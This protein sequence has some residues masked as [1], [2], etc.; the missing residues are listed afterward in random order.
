ITA[1][2]AFL[3][4]DSTMYDLGTLGGT[5]SFACGIN[6]SG[7][8]VGEASITGD[9]A[10]HAFLY[11]G[12][13][14]FDLNT[15]IDPLSGWI[16]ESVMDIN[17]AGLIV[18]KGYNGSQYHAFL[19]TPVPEPSTVCLLCLDLIGFLTYKRHSQKRASKTTQKHIQSVTDQFSQSLITISGV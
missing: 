8:I 18:G 3:Y 10:S 15:L 11:S 19:L 17:D 14:M 9:A 16:L 13:T 12:S 6:N 5:N 1:L 7:Q 2:H 4:T